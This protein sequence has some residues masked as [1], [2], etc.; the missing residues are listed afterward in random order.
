MTNNH[1]YHVYHTDLQPSGQTA[2]TDRLGRQRHYKLHK[3]INI[4]FNVNSLNSE[5]NINMVYTVQG[6]LG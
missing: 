3:L 1:V 5:H 2:N 6:V 4:D